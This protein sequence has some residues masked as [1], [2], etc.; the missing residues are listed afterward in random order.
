MSLKQI[1][2]PEEELWISQSAICVLNID[3]AYYYEYL[4]SGASAL[5]AA[6]GQDYLLEK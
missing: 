3:F 5:I 1:G 6:K 2:R 4:D